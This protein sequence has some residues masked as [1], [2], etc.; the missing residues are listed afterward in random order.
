MDRRAI[1]RASFES[2]EYARHVYPDELRNLV[3]WSGSW[4]EYW[5]YGKVYENRYWFATLSPEEYEALKEEWDLPLFDV[6][7]NI[8]VDDDGVWDCYTVE[9]DQ[10][11]MVSVKHPYRDSKGRFEFWGAYGV[12]YEKMFCIEFLPSDPLYEADTDP[13][14]L[15]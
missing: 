1:Y 13:K 8:V 7:T 15:P 3:P 2:G 6:E 12:D 14:A 9:P 11:T 5:P 4:K 10:F